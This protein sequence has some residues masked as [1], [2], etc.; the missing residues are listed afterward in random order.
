MATRLSILTA[1]RTRLQGILRTAGFATDAGALVRLGEA[2]ELAE[3]DPDAALA[4]VVRDDTVKAQGKKLFITLPIA[5]YA[6]GKVNLDEPWEAIEDLLLDIKA[7][8]E[9]DDLRLGGLLRA[10]M[11]R[12][13]TRTIDREPGSLTF[14]ASIAYYLPYDETWGGS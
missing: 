5:V 4:I 6:L 2:F 11:E 13:S 1:V 14:G 9:T 8:M 7:V 10:S 3:N 12:G